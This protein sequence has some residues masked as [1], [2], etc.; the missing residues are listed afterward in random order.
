MA[1]G[2]SC[3]LVVLTTRRGLREDADQ[4]DY[5]FKTSVSGSKHSRRRV[6]WP[7]SLAGPGDCPAGEEPG[8]AE[9]AGKAVAFLK[10]RQGRDGSWS[11]DREPG[12]TALVVTAMLRSGRITPDDPAIGKGLAFLEQ[13]VGPKGGLSEAL[14][15]S[16]RPRLP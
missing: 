5:A 3:V 11:G 13:Y 16:T 4:D 15:R 8:A 6:D 14:I 2:E 1:V 12:I 10:P 9:L 7:V